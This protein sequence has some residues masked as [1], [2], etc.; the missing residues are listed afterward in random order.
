MLGSLLEYAHRAGIETEPGFSPET[1]KWEIR[2]STSGKFVGVVEM[3]NLD[4]KINHGRLFESVPKYPPNLMQSGGKSHFLTDSLGTLVPA[5]V[6]KAAGDPS[7]IPQKAITKHEFFL[8]LLRQASREDSALALLKVVA[9]A[10]SNEP[11]VEKLVLALKGKKA[12]HT[13]KATFRIGEFS[14]LEGSTWRDWWRTYRKTLF[15]A[16]S[17][18]KQQRSLATGKLIDPLESHQK[19][20]GLSGVGG[21]G[22]GDSLISFDKE[23]F[24]SYGLKQSRNAPI[25]EEAVSAYVSGLNHLLSRGKRV[26]STKVI[27]WYSKNLSIDP[28]EVVESPAPFL[29][30]WGDSA[31]EVEADISEVLGSIE[32]GSS[33]ETKALDCRFSAMVLSGNQGRVVVRDWLEGDLGNLIKN[34]CR[35][36]NDLKIVRLDGSSP[37]K[38]P[39]FLGVLGSTVA[40]L[41]M[42]DGPFV[43]AMWQAAIAGRSF[44]RRAMFGALNRFKSDLLDSER[45]NQS[46]MGLLRAILNRNGGREMNEKI[47]WKIDID[48][49]EPAY[50]CG[51]LLAVFARLQKAAVPNVK[52]GLVQRYYAAASST[53]ALV[54]GRLTRLSQHHLA[55]LEGGLPYWF[56]NK[57]SEVAERITTYPK[58]LSLEQ[59]SLFALGYY[60]QVALLRAEKSK[61]KKK[62]D[63]ND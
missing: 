16:T 63:Q 51:R 31:V 33:P 23:S 4:D 17:G 22:T 47:D 41:D 5:M 19:I 6:A 49:R 21:R 45:M 25:E 35:W 37:A 48:R 62:E 30:D 10:L 54:L 34:I 15:D 8:S 50:H 20:K 40:D 43:I 11:K 59:Q 2:F 18:K 32:V 52:A 12:K 57:I 42:L 29:D 7:T 46:R 60:Q 13:D 56:E 44:P 27:H 9:D 39:K 61:N 28:M 3:G 26:A 38:A 36:F 55:K 14:P 1:I 58:V 24:C 53:P